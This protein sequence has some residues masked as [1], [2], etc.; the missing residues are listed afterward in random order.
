MRSIICCTLLVGQGAR[1]CY[2]PIIARLSLMNLV[3]SLTTQA[4]IATSALTV[5]I[6]LYLLVVLPRFKGVHPD[7]SGCRGALTLATGPV[8]EGHLPSQQYKNWRTSSDLSLLVP[9]SLPAPRQPSA[10]ASPPSLTRPFPLSIV[11]KQILT[12][13]IAS[14]W[15][16]LLIS[17]ANW[18]HLNILQ[19]IA[20]CKSDRRRTREVFYFQADHIPRTS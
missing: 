14:G 19:S 10:R 12:T 16:L 13:S 18:T 11:L 20:G 5:M 6:F 8:A 7:V 3:A 2:L 15:I 17:L 9:V 4:C 1:H